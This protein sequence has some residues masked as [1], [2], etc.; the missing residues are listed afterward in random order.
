VKKGDAVHIVFTSSQ[1]FHDWKVDE[2]GAATS[3]VST[4]Q[5]D[6]VV[7]IADTAGSFEYY[8]SVGNH[9]AQGMVGTLVVEE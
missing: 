1:G 8:C 6:E 5:T 2:F 7:F 4:G 9:R 3:V